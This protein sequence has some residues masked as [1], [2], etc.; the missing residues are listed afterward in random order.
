MTTEKEYQKIKNKP[1]CRMEVRKQII[2]SIERM[3]EIQRG[4][5]NKLREL[6]L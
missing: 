5:E 2:E 1:S 6:L 4:T 3:K